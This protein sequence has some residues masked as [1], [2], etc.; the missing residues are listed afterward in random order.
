[1]PVRLEER[2]ATPSG[3][4]ASEGEAGAGLTARAPLMCRPTL[5]RRSSKSE[6]GEGKAAAGDGVAGVPD[7]LKPPQPGATK[8]TLCRFG[9]AAG[10]SAAN[11]KARTPRRQKRQA[12]EPMRHKVSWA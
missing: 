6:G 12:R 8:T 3:P 7:A 9:G 5:P 2:P 4:V 11:D 10:V 1:V